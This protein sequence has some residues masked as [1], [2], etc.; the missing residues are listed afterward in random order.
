M[1]SPSIR[2]PLVAVLIGGAALAA[3]P[4]AA[5]AASASLRT[6]VSD[7][8]GATESR[9]G[10]ERSK[11]RLWVDAD[12][13]GCDTR[14]EVLIAEAVKAPTVGSGCSLTNGRWVSPY[15]DASWT[16]IADL[17]IDHLVPLAEAWDS[18]ASAWT[19][20]RRES[21]ANDLGDP[22][23]LIAVTDNVNQAKGDQ[24]PAEWVPPLASY[25]C[26]Y[27]A[28]WVATKLRWKLTVDGAERSA[29][30]QSAAGCPATTISW[31]VAG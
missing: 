5:S 19:A 2:R 6:A 17:D 20:A 8:P 13:D 1:R 21:Y 15:D 30:A 16:D 3:V 27:T 23:S 18:G 11:F 9:T 28:D 4:S 12:G 26:T 14:R 10:Y 29:L 25:R 7:L 22:R 31:T 24:D